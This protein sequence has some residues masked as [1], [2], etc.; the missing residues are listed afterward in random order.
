MKEQW[1]WPVLLSPEFPLIPAL[2][3]LALKLVNLILPHMTQAIL[4]LMHVAG[5]WSECFVHK[6]FKNSVLISYCPSSLSDKIS[7]DFQTKVLCGLLFP[8]QVPWGGELSVGLKYLAPQGGTSWLRYPSLFW[9][10]TLWVSD[11]TRLYI[12]PSYLRVASSS[13]INCKNSAQIFFSL[14]WAMVVLYFV[15][16]VEGYEFRIYL[17]HHLDR[18][19]PQCLYTF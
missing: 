9:I 2:L 12:W 19:H 8:E 15:V 16:F 18:T 11:L 7:A 10:A 1:W 17:L 6:P 5:T 13:Y 3:T 4:E 14:F